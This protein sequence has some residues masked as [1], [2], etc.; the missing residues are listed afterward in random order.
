MNIDING[1]TILSGITAL[2]V[3]W[4]YAKWREAVHYYYEMRNSHD[5]VLTVC[6]RV[7]Q[8]LTHLREEG[9][10]EAAE[11]FKAFMN[12]KEALRRVG[13]EL[14]GIDEVK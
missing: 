1:I 6:H 14:H 13:A 8:G 5:I 11:L 12:D 7:G 10:P 4:G 9:H 2:A 3:V